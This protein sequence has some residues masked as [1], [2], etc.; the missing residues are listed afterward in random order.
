LAL[1]LFLQPR[2]SAKLNQV[3]IRRHDTPLAQL[4]EIHEIRFILGGT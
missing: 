3:K 2:K 1:A 4:S